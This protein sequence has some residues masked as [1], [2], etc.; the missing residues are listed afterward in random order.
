M[1]KNLLHTGFMLVLATSCVSNKKFTLLQKD[2]LQAT[3]LPVDSIVREYD[4]TP[5]DYRLPP[6]DLVYITFESLTPKD[7]DF[8]N[9]NQILQN[10]NLNLGGGSALLIGEL[11][12][13]NGEIPFPFLGKIK[14]SGLT[15]FQAQD[16]LQQ[17]AKEYL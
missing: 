5:F 12:D 6:E 7:F 14:L 2:D 11:I 15:V 4:R 8:L 3:D 13:K 17:I 10:A 9:Q 16:K 1:I